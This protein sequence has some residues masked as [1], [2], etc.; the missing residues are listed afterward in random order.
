[1]V[2]AP[3]PQGPPPGTDREE[4]YERVVV[5]SLRALAEALRVG[6]AKAPCKTRRLE[7]EAS[8]GQDEANLGRT[9]YYPRLKLLR[10]TGCKKR[11]SNAT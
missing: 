8:R 1:M 6:E 5:A 10:K 9:A 11:H 4:R 2:P 7:D 3:S